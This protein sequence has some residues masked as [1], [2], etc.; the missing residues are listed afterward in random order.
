[1]SSISIPQII[2]PLEFCLKNTYF[3][4]QGKY[5][6]QVHGLPIGS[7]TSP[8]IANLFMEEFKVKVISSAPTLPTYGSGMWMTPFS[9][10]RQKTVNSSS[11][12]QLPRLSYPIYYWQPEGRWFHTLSGHPLQPQFTTNLPTQTDT[13]NGTATTSSWPNTVYTTP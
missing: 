5:F 3:P 4:F 10:N 1:M 12:N 6:E 7:T 8:L 2:T 9:F 11:S 13:Y